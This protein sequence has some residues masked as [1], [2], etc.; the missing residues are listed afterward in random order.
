M[1]SQ[2]HPQTTDLISKFQTLYR[3]A[4]EWAWDFAPSIPFIGKRYQPGKGLLIYASAE[5]L[6]WMLDD[7]REEYKRFFLGD[8]VW[9]RYR[10]QYDEMDNPK[11]HFFPDIG[12]QPVTN[13]GLLAAGL[14]IAQET[15]IPEENP[16]R[17]F[18][19]SIAA[20]NWC[21]Y[22]KLAKNGNNK[23]SDYINKPKYTV[24]SLSY[25]V[26]E[27]TALQPA[28]VLLPSNVWKDVASR[29]AMRGASPSTLFMPAP[30]FSS[31]V[32]NCN[33]DKYERGTRQLR[34][35]FAGHVLDSWMNQLIKLNTKNAW[36]Y[37]AMLQTQLS[38]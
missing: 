2:L 9:N 24:K 11:G 15:G 36:R 34:K 21:K 18:L 4:P 37:I 29:Q 16:P 17:C 38:Q 22:T 10:L 25:V 8:L 14:F 35:R 27:L 30:Q 31:T 33:L 1:A 6:T 26:A 32:I 28:A 5:N 3:G 19:E 13:G 12:I 20:S 7:K 23:N